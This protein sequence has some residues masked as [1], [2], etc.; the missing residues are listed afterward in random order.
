MMHSMTD[1]TATAAATAR[2]VLIVEDDAPIRELVRFHLTLAGFAV[3]ELG[4]GAAAL[5]RA[6]TTAF[7]LIVLDIMP[8]GLDGITLCRALRTEGANVATPILMVTA[9][10]TESDK[11][12]GLESGADDYL[13]KPFGVRELVA[14]VT[15]LLRR[16]G[17]VDRGTSETRQVIR[18]GLILDADNAELRSAATMATTLFGARPGSGRAS[19]KL[20]TAFCSISNETT[21]ATKLSPSLK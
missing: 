4:D 11:V 13:T 20:K 5:D 17:R 7:E 8:P 19:T 14:R 9:R 2:R 10:D 18:G 16:R 21:K 15:A 6:R 3:T 1:V 12:L